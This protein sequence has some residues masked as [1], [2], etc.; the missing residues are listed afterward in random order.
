M[1]GLLTDLPPVTL[2]EKVPEISVALNE[3]LD[4]ETCS[5]CGL[6]TGDISFGAVREGR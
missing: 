3:G 5:L 4:G 1:Y 6:T 2:V